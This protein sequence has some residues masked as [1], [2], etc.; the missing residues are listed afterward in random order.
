MLLRSP[1]PLCDPQP[2]RVKAA[3]PKIHFKTLFKTGAQGLAC[4]G[5]PGVPCPLVSLVP[6]LHFALALTARRTRLVRRFFFN[7]LLRPDRNPTRQKTSTER[8][9]HGNFELLPPPV[10]QRL[11]AWSIMVTVTVTPVL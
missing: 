9:L 2:S 10:F 8:D 6:W 7:L 5:L 3:A 11:R 4:R 1:A